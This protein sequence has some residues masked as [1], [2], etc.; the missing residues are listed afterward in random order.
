MPPLPMSSRI[1]SCGNFA[2]SSA[3]DGGVKE[4]CFASVTE[5]AAAP[6]L[7]RQ[8]GQ[9]PASAPEGR[10]VPH[11]GHLFDSAIGGSS[12]TVSMPTSEAKLEKCYTESLKKHSTFNIQQPTLKGCALLR[13]MLNVECFPKFPA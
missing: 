8:A 10:G 13:S 3:T 6:A 12:F 9:S 5:S 4:F 11:C 1:S 2:A 7:S